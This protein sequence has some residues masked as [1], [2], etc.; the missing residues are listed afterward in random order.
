[1][2]V[3]CLYVSKLYDKNIVTSR[4]YSDYFAW[5]MISKER[6][7]ISTITTTYPFSFGLI[8]KNSQGKP[9]NDF[10]NGDDANSHC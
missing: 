8:S 7:L 3:G 1:M 2:P 10:Y 9:V 5:K 6:T 4:S